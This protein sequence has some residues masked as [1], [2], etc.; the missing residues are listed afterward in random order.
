MTPFP[1]VKKMEPK[2]GVFALDG[3]VAVKGESDPVRIFQQWV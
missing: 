3:S 1:K 2:A